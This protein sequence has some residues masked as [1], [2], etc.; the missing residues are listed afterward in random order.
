MESELDFHFSEWCFLARVDPDAFERRRLRL[1][2]D[3]ISHSGGQRPRLE[4]LQAAIDGEREKAGSATEALL[5]LSRKM[6]GS[7]WLLQEELNE[8]SDDLHRLEDIQR[9]KSWIQA[10]GSA[11][12]RRYARPLKQLY[13]CRLRRYGK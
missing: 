13:R 10:R 4:S 6:C 7:L 1:I 3:F 2:E 5:M 9:F 12:S 8:L 11:E